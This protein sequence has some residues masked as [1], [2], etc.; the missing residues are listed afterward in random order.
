LGFVL[1]V[2]LA[3]GGGLPRG[4][5]GFFVVFYLGK[6]AFDFFFGG[7]ALSGGMETVAGTAWRRC[8]ALGRCSAAKL[9]S[10][11]TACGAGTMD[12]RAKAF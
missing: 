6:G 3:R 2:V 10:A 7:L 11:G 12:L 5:A 8:A 1:P 4:F 9:V